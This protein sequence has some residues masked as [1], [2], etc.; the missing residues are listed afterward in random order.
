MTEHPRA[1]RYARFNLGVAQIRSGDAAAGGATLD[2]LGRSGAPDEELRSLRD[3]ANV[4]LGF[5]ACTTASSR[6]PT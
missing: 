5:S 6:A 2:E 3:R 4:A 1:G